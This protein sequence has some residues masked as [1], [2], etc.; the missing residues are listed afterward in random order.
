VEYQKIEILFYTISSPAKMS[1]PIDAWKAI[2]K[3]HEEQLLIAKNKLQEMEAPVNERV[4]MAE[5]KKRVIALETGSSYKVAWKTAVE[6]GLLENV[7]QILHECYDS[8]LED[9]DAEFVAKAKQRMGK[10]NSLKWQLF[11][12]DVIEHLKNDESFFYRDDTYDFDCFDDTAGGCDE[13]TWD[14]GMAVI[15]NTPMPTASPAAALSLT[16]AILPL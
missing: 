15:N 4:T 9:M 1:S 5:M 6:N 16:H 10:L 13:I 8:Y 11:T 2:A 3:F 14:A 12:L 7:E